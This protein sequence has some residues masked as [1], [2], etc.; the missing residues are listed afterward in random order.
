M[1]SVFQKAVPV[2][3]KIEEAGFEAYFV[4]GSVRDVLLEKE[5]DDVD[6]ATSAT[7]AEI[8][9]IFSRTID[10]GIEHGTVVV[11]FGGQSY[12]VTTFRCE[13]NYTDYRRPSQVSFIRSLEEDL[14][15]RDFTMNA[16]AM[17]KEGKLI[18]PFNG[19]SAI[20]EKVIITVGAAK[21]R[22]Q[23]DALRMMRAVRFVSQL[24]FSIEELTYAALE[25][26]R[27]LLANI[28]VERIMIEFEKTLL[29]KNRQE[30]IRVLIDTKL[31]EYL[32]GLRGQ[33]N[34][35]S[36]FSKLEMNS[37]FSIE[38][39]WVILLFQLR[40]GAEEIEGLLKRWKL[41][42]KKIRR[43]KRGLIWLNFRTN[44]LWRTE[45]LYSA[46]EELVVSSEKLYNV[47]EK[48]EISLSINDLL[49]NLKLLPI[50]ERRELSITGIDL[51]NWY[52][53]NGGPWIEELLQ[54]VEKAVLLREVHN[55]KEAIREWLFKCNQN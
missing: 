8:K 13:S 3:Q 32:P 20:H 27:H 9:A 22:F 35:L 18:D 10:V 19:A 44:N 42:T 40:I 21:E 43:I 6:I 28:S 48:Q 47:L 54:K 2:L 1:K 29:G 11:L 31:F 17:D 14:K 51:M 33:E 25:K 15:R 26:N 55:G 36:Q 52:A 16:I 39:Y 4:G 23:E 12:E 30:A 50:K 46:G 38:E 41:P 53:K 24:S 34:G 49:D 5:I 7:P 45:D 37:D